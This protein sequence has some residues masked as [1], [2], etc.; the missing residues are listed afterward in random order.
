MADTTVNRRAFSS[1][2]AAIVIGGV[3]VGW[4]Q[5]F[6]ARE[7]V[8]SVPI[9]VLGEMYTQRFEP[10]NAD[11]SGSF[12]LIHLLVEPLSGLITSSAAGNT[13][14]AWASHILST[15]QWI[16]YD[17]PALSLVDLN[18]TGFRAGSSGNRSVITVIGMMPEGRSFTIS[19]G[20]LL[21]ENCNFNAIK[22]E[23]H[24]VAIETL[25]IPT[26]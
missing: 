22:I 9:K 26:V 17:P 18:T 3:P 7:S 16:A 24:R 6:Q 21:M 14:R 23:E 19:Q 8:T 13:V 4:A 15:Q 12:D 25:Q 5:G 20:G 1:P 10:V 2:R 11:A